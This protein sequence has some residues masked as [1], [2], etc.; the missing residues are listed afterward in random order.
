MQNGQ[1]RFARRIEAPRRNPLK[2]AGRRLLSILAIDVK[3]LRHAR[4]IAGD[5]RK[6]YTAQAMGER[7]TNA[8]EPF[9]S[10][11]CHRRQSTI[12]CCGFEIRERLESQVV[13]EP[14]RKHPAYSGDRC[15]EPHGIGFATQTIEHRQA[16][17]HRQLAN[18]A[19]DCLAD[20]WDL[21]ETVESAFAKHRIHWRWHRTDAGRSTQIRFHPISIRPLGTQQFRCLLKASRDILVDRVHVR[22]G[23]TALANVPSTGP[24]ARFSPRAKYSAWCGNSPRAI[25]P[26]NIVRPLDSAAGH[27]SHSAR[28]SCEAVS[29][30]VDYDG[31]ALS[32]PLR[33]GPR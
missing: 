15:E 19:G 3:K 7:V 5:D 1:P 32:S 26:M 25:S 9:R 2:F 12:M 13:V 16:S 28:A 17:V 10:K 6:A 18:R 31:T 30:R 23:C 8:S 33:A 11:T 4:R 22:I 29:H 27:F 21:L 14:I 24:Q 20:M